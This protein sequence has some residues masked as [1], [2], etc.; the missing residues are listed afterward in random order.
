MGVVSLFVGI[1]IVVGTGKPGLRILRKAIHRC[2]PWFFFRSPQPDHSWV[3]SAGAILD[4]AS[5]MQSTIDTPD[6]PQAALCIRAGYLAL[7]RIGDIFSISYDSTPQ[8]GD[9]VSITRI[10]FD[11][12]VADLRST[13]IPLKADL[14]L[15]WLDFCG[16]RVNYDWVLLALANLT[17][18]PASPWTGSRDPDYHLP[19]LLW[20]RKNSGS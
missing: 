9:P 12:V 6:D 5:L 14:E 11:Q 8:R 1:L 7:R 10:E 17:M 2:R 19:R 4:T 3:T 15:A 20:A 18:A 16:W 13:G